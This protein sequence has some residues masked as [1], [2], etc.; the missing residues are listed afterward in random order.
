MAGGCPTWQRV[1]KQRDRMYYSKKPAKG[2]APAFIPLN[3]AQHETTSTHS[4]EDTNTPAA[5]KTP[6]CK[7]KSTCGKA[8]SP[9]E[10]TCQRVRL[11]D[12]EEDRN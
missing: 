3:N 10:G 11:A 1:P 9:F 2:K 7:E 6:G 4:Y 5:P 8:A 12:Q